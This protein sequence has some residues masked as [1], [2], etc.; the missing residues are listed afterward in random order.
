M[1][2]GGPKGPERIPKGA[3]D[4]PKGSPREPKGSPREP[5]VAPGGLK[6]SERVPKDD[7]SEHETHRYSPEG[8]QAECATRLNDIR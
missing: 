2:P 4:A 3:F 5:S 6:W 1:V 8:G 7:K